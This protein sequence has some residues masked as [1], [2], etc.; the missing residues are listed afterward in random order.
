T[1]TTEIYT[2]SLHDA[3]P[4]YI[5]C[6]RRR[7]EHWFA[8][9]ERMV[10]VCARGYQGIHDFQTAALDGQY[11]R[12]NPVPIRRVRLRVLRQQGSHLRQIPV[13]RSVVQRS[14]A[15]GIV[16]AERRDQQQENTK[17]K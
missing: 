10:D 11:Q 1:A 17:S 5:S 9:R 6:T 2:L 4:I 12:R 14:R 7:H 13:A 8:C 16:R 15:V 3:L